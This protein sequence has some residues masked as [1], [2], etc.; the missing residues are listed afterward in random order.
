MRVLKE[1]VKDKIFMLCFIF[2]TLVVLAG[3]FAPL[4]APHAPDAINI[5]E[6][7]SGPSLTYPFG[8]DRLGRCML[9]RLIYGIRNT[10][11]LAA[12][13]MS[14]TI[15]LGALLGIISGF[16]RGVFDEI[17]MRVC[18]VMMSFPS[19]VM[20]LAIVGM[21]GPSLK[22][23]IIANIL[24][25]WPWYTR[26]IRGIVLQYRSK[27]YIQFAKVCGRRNID[28]IIEHLLPGIAGELCVLATLDG[29]AVILTISALSFLGLGAQPP[30]AEWGVM[31]NEAKAV[32]TTH[33]ALMIAPGFAIMLVVASCNF[34]GDSLQKALNP[35]RA[36]SQ[37][38]GKTI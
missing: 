13:A 26:M 36:V 12:L 32:L 1:L 31:L 29:G 7:L 11:F 37:T 5:K 17:I 15:M 25:K 8:T 21:M 27:H 18:D 22:N 4:A 23:V 10:V 24:A 19:E 3:I 28:I 30:T 20:I 9:S 6:K 33:S 34:I 2:L 16:M 14:I 38:K 35:K